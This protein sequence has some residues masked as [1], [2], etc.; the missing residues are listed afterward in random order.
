M[1][2]T[3]TATST[4]SPSKDKRSFAVFRSTAEGVRGEH[5]S[6]AHSRQ[7]NKVAKKFAFKNAPADA[8][9]TT[10]VMVV[11]R[12]AGPGKNK[13]CK[14]YQ[15]K[16]EMKPATPSYQKI[17]IARKYKNVD[18]MPVVSIVGKAKTLVTNK[19]K[20]VKKAAAEANEQA[21][22]SNSAARDQSPVRVKRSTS[23]SSSPAH[24]SE[25]P[26]AAKPKRATKK[27]AAKKPAT[28][29]SKKAS[30]KNVGA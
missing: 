22:S 20:T 17:A 13:P 4:N 30:N 3:A 12:Q 15:L 8:D 29:A 5:I 21:S 19:R 24:E 23:R 14:L 10:W 16:R 25:T 2:A 27:A 26:V 9:E 28:G 11:L 18:T 6:N 7:W 1:A